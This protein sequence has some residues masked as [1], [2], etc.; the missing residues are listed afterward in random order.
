MKEHFDKLLLTFLIL[1]FLITYVVGEVWG[2]AQLS[3]AG[4]TIDMLTGALTALITGA[5]R[6]A[7]ARIVPPSNDASTSPDA[8]ERKQ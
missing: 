8:G 3:F 4:R 5:V 1:V 6:A 2:H 7:V